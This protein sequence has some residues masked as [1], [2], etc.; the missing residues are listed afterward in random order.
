MSSL[1]GGRDAV[2][3]RIGRSPRFA[4]VTRGIVGAV[5]L[6][7]S[8]FKLTTGSEPFRSVLEGLTFLDGATNWQIV[9]LAAVIIGGEFWIG[10]ELMLGRC[11]QVCVLAAV[12]L[13]TTFSVVIVVEHAAFLNG[14]ACMW[15]HP[16]WLLAQPA[17][18]VA[19]NVLMLALL[20]PSLR[21]RAPPT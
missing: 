6:A 15:G 1:H 18:I 20:L 14:C 3:H 16:N 11:R 19:R 5:F 13:L 7:A 9:A 2:Y 21:Q 17:G 4:R 10:M 8:A 12:A